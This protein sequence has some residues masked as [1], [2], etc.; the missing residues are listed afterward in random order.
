MK[1]TKKLYDIDAYK[2]NFDAVVLVC[3]EIDL[4]GQK[5][6]QVILN[7]TLFF[8]EEGGQSP[9]KGTINGIQVIDVQIKNNI[10]T[11]TLMLPCNVGDS[12]HGVIDW[13]HR[14]HNMQ[15]HTGEHIFSGLVNQTYGY[16]NV[17]FHLSDQIVTMDFNG[18]L[19]QEQVSE[20]EY[21]AN[22]V[23]IRNIPI[24]VSF[25][26]KEQL[27]TMSYRSKIEIDGQ[28][29]IVSIPGVDACACCAPHVKK[30][31]EVG[32]LKVMNVQNYK[33]GVRISILCGF[34]ALMEFR[35]KATIVAEISNILS[36]NQDNIVENV[37]KLKNTN[38]SLKAQLISAKQESFSA[39]LKEIPKDQSD[40]YLFEE[41]LD[42]TIM[43]NGVNLLVADHE[44]I[45]GIFSGNDADGYRYIIGSNTVDVR[46]TTTVL[47]EKLG[48][49]GGGSKTM[50]QG[51]VFAT[52]TMIREIL[53]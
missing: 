12:V 50:V 47:R 4:S 48:A 52:E 29:R 27:A 39:K 3:E 24:E 20:I 2:T 40:I 30:T 37:I 46:N 53:L 44:G 42:A 15:Q 36:T 1:Q 31:A 18:V 45:C 11:H 43:R 10:I 13:S 32:I 35:K 17:G 41:D 23:I 25:P 22:E 34:R 16:D 51:S 14:F 26:E 38:Q 33:G 21:A 49:K 19:T 9:D 5:A 6:Y 28:V 8:P 7:Q